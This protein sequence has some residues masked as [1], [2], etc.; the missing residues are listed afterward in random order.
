MLLVRLTFLKK[1]NFF[2]RNLL[3]SSLISKPLESHSSVL[4]T[5]QVMPLPTFHHILAPVSLRSHISFIFEDN[6]D[7]K[8]CKNTRTGVDYRGTLSL[9]QSGKPC[10]ASTI[11]PG[12]S[13]IFLILGLEGL[14]P[15]DRK[16]PRKRPKRAILQKPGWWS[17][18]T[19]VLYNWRK[20]G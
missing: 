20:L 2:L 13:H 4:T 12:S 18:R 17:R 19:L 16:V 3:Y 1:I 7:P 5:V 11:L 9:T 15:M 8:E 10:K 6:F 14:P